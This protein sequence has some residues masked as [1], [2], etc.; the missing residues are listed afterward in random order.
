MKRTNQDKIKLKDQLKDLYRLDEDA[1]DERILSKAFE[2]MKLYKALKGWFPGDSCDIIQELDQHRR[3][4]FSD[5]RYPFGMVTIDATNY[6]LARIR[7]VYGPGTVQVT[8][9]LPPQEYRVRSSATADD[10]ETRSVETNQGLPQRPALF[11][12]VLYSGGNI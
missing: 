4:L 7:L 10:G 5:R 3:V 12:Y 1:T 8:G 2:H 6:V 11:D 9:T